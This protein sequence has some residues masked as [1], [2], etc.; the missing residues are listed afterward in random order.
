M[1]T[2]TGLIPTLHHTHS[3][4]DGHIVLSNGQVRL[5]VALCQLTQPS[6]SGTHFSQ[7]LVYDTV[8]SVRAL[9][10][11]SSPFKAAVSDHD[12]C[13]PTPIEDSTAT[14]YHSQGPGQTHVPPD[15]RA[16]PP[17]SH[18]TCPLKRDTHADK[19]DGMR[20]KSQPA[21]TLG[22]RRRKRVG[23]TTNRGLTNQ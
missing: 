19:A 14:P 23:Y 20:L 13:L 5:T 12:Y 7:T 15:H 22:E 1:P 11:V 18:P 6:K 8:Q 4:N 2:D 21:P 10:L 16:N 17:S 9:Q 3:P